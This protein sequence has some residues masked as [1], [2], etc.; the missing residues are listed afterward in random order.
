MRSRSCTRFG[1]SVSASWRAMCD[2][3]ASMRR[4]RVTSSCVATQ[5][6]PSIGSCV[7][8]MMRPS[9]S[10]CSLVLRTASRAEASRSSRYASAFS[11]T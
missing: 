5:P 11:P 1:R 3:F 2:I 9:L 10:S 4:S 8:A 6:P 7:M